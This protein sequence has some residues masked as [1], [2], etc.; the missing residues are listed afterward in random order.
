MRV[1]VALI[2]GT[3][4]GSMVASGY[5]IVVNALHAAAH[6]QL[7]YAAN[8]AGLD[9]ALGKP[10]A[11]LL[12]LGSLGILT[13]SSD[14]AA[15]DM[16]LAASAMLHEAIASQHVTLFVSSATTLL[17]LS[18][19]FSLVVRDRL[20]ILRS[21]IAVSLTTLG[22][23]ISAPIV[24]VVASRSGLGG[25]IVTSDCKSIASAISTLFHSG[26]ATIATLLVLFSVVTPLLKCI[27]L[28]TAATS[29]GGKAGT[30]AARVVGW[31]GKWSMVDVLVV[32]I[33]L[34][35]FSVEALGRG[36]A[37]M[38]AESEVGL[39]FFVA[40][41]LTSMVAGALL[42]RGYLRALRTAPPLQQG[43]GVLG[44][45][46]ATAACAAVL[47]LFH[48]GRVVQQKFEIAAGNL[49]A[50]AVVANCE[51]TLHGKWTARGD[52]HG[53]ADDTLVHAHYFAPA[54]KLLRTL[55]H[56]H[57]DDFSVRAE[58]AGPYVIV[59]DNLGIIRSTAR[60]VDVEWT[61]TAAFPLHW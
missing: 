44:P 59:F 7:H 2:A 8:R 19:A 50:V 43:S 21:L 17:A 6:E 61:F 27:L 29:A 30:L 1:L 58:T 48:P 34:A 57:S 52:T 36:A 40:H 33:L 18:L 15:A 24:S 4:F 47:C 35:L 26:Y 28:S 22:I 39:W 54:C 16:A 32:A 56:P 14:M 23:G 60:T 42:S 13:P 41:C 49:R 53:G 20:P 9:N 25:G 10:L 46:T 31:I 37:D 3:L 5:R 55:D 51:G 12:E 45:L 11:G 38:L